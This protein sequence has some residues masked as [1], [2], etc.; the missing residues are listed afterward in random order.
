[1][2]GTVEKATPAR[3]AV[4][5]RLGPVLERRTDGRLW[6]T[7]EGVETP[8]YV[9]RCFPW[10]EP[11]RFFSLRDQSDDEV[12]MVSSPAELDPDSRTALE[13]SLAEA[14]F[15]FHLS[16]VESIEEEVEL[17]CWDATTTQGARRFQTRVD[18]WP[19][20]LADGRLLIRD[21]A[22]DLYLLPARQALSPR[23]LEVLWAF[24]D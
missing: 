11:T 24:L 1:V 23:S 4:I 9:S 16:S 5:A 17:R 7:G 6:F 12:A 10:S 8:V 19:D 2:S 22:G 21:V 18:E 14:G 20:R 13:H 15:V 3:T